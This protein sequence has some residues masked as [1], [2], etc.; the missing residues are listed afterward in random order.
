MKAKRD[1]VMYNLI[2]ANDPDS[3]HVKFDVLLPDNYSQMKIDYLN[4]CVI[5]Q[6][7]LRV[8]DSIKFRFS[9][10]PI[11]YDQAKLK[12]QLIHNDDS[13]VD[14]KE[15]DHTFR[16]YQYVS[17]DLMKYYRI[18][19]L[20]V[21][22]FWDYKTKETLY[23]FNPCEKEYILDEPVNPPR[24]ADIF[25]HGPTPASNLRATFTGNYVIGFEA[26]DKI[27]DIELR[28]GESIKNSKQRPEEAGSYSFTSAVSNELT[29]QRV[30][31]AN[32]NYGQDWTYPVKNLLL[33]HRETIRHV[34]DTTDLQL[35]YAL[36][37]KEER[38]VCRDVVLNDFAVY[39]GEST[40]S[41][42]GETQDIIFRK[43]SILSGLEPLTANIYTDMIQIEQLQYTPFTKEGGNYINVYKSGDTD[44]FVKGEAIPSYNTNGG[45]YYRDPTYNVPT[46]L[47]PNDGSNPC[48]FINPDWY[49]TAQSLTIKVWWREDSTHDW[50][51]LEDA[52]DE[53]KFFIKGVNNQTSDSSPVQIH[54]TDWNA[55]FPLYGKWESDQWLEIKFEIFLDDK[56]RFISMANLEEN[57]TVNPH[58]FTAFADLYIYGTL[59][60]NENGEAI[61]YNL[62]NTGLTPASRAY[63]K[64]TDDIFKEPGQLTETFIRSNMT[65]NLND[66]DLMVKAETDSL[67]RYG[68]KFGLSNLNNNIHTIR[69][70][71][72]NPVIETTET[73]WKPGFD[74]F[75]GADARDMKLLVFVPKRSTRGMTNFYKRN[76]ER[77]FFRLTDS[78]GRDTVELLDNKTDYFLATGHSSL[79]PDAP[80]GDDTKY[81]TFNGS[82]IFDRSDA[83]ITRLF[84]NDT[85]GAC[86]NYIN[87]L[88]AA[89]LARY[90]YVADVKTFDAFFNTER[91]LILNSNHRTLYGYYSN[92]NFDFH[93]GEHATVMSSCMDIVKLLGSENVVN[94]CFSILSP[95]EQKIIVNPITL[96]HAIDTPGDILKAPALFPYKFFHLYT[97]GTIDIPYVGMTSTD[98]EQTT[99][100]GVN[101][102]KVDSSL[103]LLM[104]YGDSSKEPF[105][106]RTNNSER[107]FY[108]INKDAGGTPTDEK[109]K[110]R[111]RM[112]NSPKYPTNRNLKYCGLIETLPSYRLY[113][114]GNF[115]QADLTIT[116]GGVKTLHP[117]YLQSTPR[118]FLNNLIYFFDF[119]LNALRRDDGTGFNA[120]NIFNFVQVLSF[121]NAAL[122]LGNDYRPILRY[123]KWYR[124]LAFK[125]GTGNMWLAESF[126]SAFVMNYLNNETVNDYATSEELATSLPNTTNQNTTN[127]EVI[128]SMESNSQYTN[129]QMFGKKIFNFFREADEF[130]VVSF[131]MAYVDVVRSADEINALYMSDSNTQLPSPNSLINNIASY[132]NLKTGKLFIPK[133]GEFTQFAHILFLTCEAFNKSTTVAIDNLN[134]VKYK[135]GFT[136]E[137]RRD[138]VDE[139]TQNQVIIYDEKFDP[140]D[141]QKI[142]VYLFGV[143]FRFH[144]L[145]LGWSNMMNEL[146]QEAF[147][148]SKTNGERHFTL[149]L[150]DDFGRLIPNQDTSQGFKN[151]CSLELTL[152]P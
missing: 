130:G 106:T 3:D 56:S 25:T 33:Q 53:Y 104:R 29:V 152:T 98:S 119:L 142:N 44:F 107:E 18:K 84:S 131:K 134:M 46:T 13:K 88:L 2:V 82:L 37:D 36:K 121:D 101:T 73:K 50:A 60:T 128:Y 123:G 10:N 23:L 76:Y 116:T 68:L 48:K 86:L 117:I 118:V 8:G 83:K 62:F 150:Y 52:G 99:V 81:K 137:K 45:L 146:V 151:N 114:N 31:A 145:S 96:S 57:T 19:Y 67:G 61:V 58:T 77:G 74:P 140:D 91:K 120:E 109:N 66:E 90:Y 122:H 51:I 108:I 21:Y 26:I 129:V 72:G 15:G 103:T 27:P 9:N 43:Y 143:M 39:D 115:E 47:D 102:R 87:D 97:S 139:E 136:K 17:L 71:Y 34:P 4:G 125:D 16:N 100:G 144:Q 92:E 28:V 70:E 64:I 113:R 32:Y 22:E 132:N 40:S 95:E 7:Y 42:Q 105:K 11:V 94:N 54:F 14:D 80:S 6:N 124:Q 69:K 59:K 148:I 89:K 12:C 112:T 30:E 93:V 55:S 133:L 63:P 78:D 1:E 135:S 38:L 75:A 85:T 141:N 138:Y 111:E 41:I 149:T 35:A 20:P 147:D 5:N 79:T 126:D 65:Y 127:E 49:Y 24:E 110:A